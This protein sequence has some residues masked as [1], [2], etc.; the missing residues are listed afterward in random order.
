[1]QLL[2]DGDCPKPIGRGYLFSPFECRGYPWLPVYTR[3]KKE[4]LSFTFI[5]LGWCLQLTGGGERDREAGSLLPDVWEFILVGEGSPVAD[6]HDGLHELV[7]GLHGALWERYQCSRKITGPLESK[8][9]RSQL[10]LVHSCNL[11]P[12]ILPSTSALFYGSDKRKP[13]ICFC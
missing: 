4:C 2:C 9:L 11:I 10:H 13:Q 5:P 8:N 3:K 6:N 7:H 1:M 12:F